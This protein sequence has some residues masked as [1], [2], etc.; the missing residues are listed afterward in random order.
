M[1]QQIVCL[2]AMVPKKAIE[3]AIRKKGA[4]SIP[5]IRKMTG[6]NSGC[7]KCTSRLEYILNTEL[8][9]SD[10]GVEHPDNY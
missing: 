8:G 2:C 1:N 9:N 10:S 4:T 7:R 6:A 5:E 3:Y